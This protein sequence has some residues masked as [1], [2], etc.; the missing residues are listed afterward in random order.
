MISVLIPTRKRVSRLD[1]ALHS[2]WSMSSSEE[3]VEILLR[4]DKDDQAT[5]EYGEVQRK[6]HRNLQILVG[7]R[8]DGY[9]SIPC[10]MNELAEAAKGTILMCCNDD[11]IF[12]TKNWDMIVEKVAKHYTDGIFD[13]GVDSILNSQYFVFSIISKRWFEIVGYI[14]DTRVPFT[15]GKYFKD[16]CDVFQRSIYVPEVIIEHDWGGY[17]HDETNNE[18]QEWLS[19]LVADPSGKWT[20]SYPKQHEAAV[21]DAVRKLRPYFDPSIRP[22]VAAK[23]MRITFEKAK[24]RV[25]LQH[26]YFPH[27][28]GRKPRL[29]ASISVYGTG[30]KF[31]LFVGRV[32]DIPMPTL[33][34]GRYKKI[35]EWLDGKPKMRALL[36]RMGARYAI[37]RI[38]K[39]NPH[40]MLR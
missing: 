26:A 19:K 1:R 18:A 11:V 36:I 25:R 17:Y 7:P 4:C 16:I 15:G 13:I 39:L 27:D 5:I 2:I 38:R 40:F 10:F 3:A 37:E 32:I 14:H 31:Q 21:D 9:V 20:E 35:L 33:H 8:N 23:G 29:I 24:P 6:W 28:V 22:I 34:R 12:R 30:N